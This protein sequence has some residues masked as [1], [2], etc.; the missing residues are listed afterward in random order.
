M[1]DEDEEY[2]YE[3]PLDNLGPD[4]E[5]LEEYRADEIATAMAEEVDN[6]VGQFQLEPPL[7]R[8]IDSG[9]AGKIARNS[10][11]DKWGFC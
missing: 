7:E 3:D 6:I 4:G 10:K 9:K 11:S 2:I 1:D 8:Q 5:I